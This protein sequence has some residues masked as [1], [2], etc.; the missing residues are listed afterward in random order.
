MPLMNST[1]MTQTS[2]IEL[3]LIIASHLPLLMAKAI[4][5]ISSSNS[6]YLFKI[7]SI[8]LNAN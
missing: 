1:K 8:P 2:E 7:A 6:L 4:I 3:Q 5:A